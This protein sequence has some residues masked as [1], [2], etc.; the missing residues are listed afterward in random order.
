MKVTTQSNTN[1]NG[2][3]YVT[4]ELN[5]NVFENILKEILQ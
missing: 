1:H 5:Y 3:R 4:K 2:P